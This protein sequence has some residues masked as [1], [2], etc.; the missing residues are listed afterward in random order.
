MTETYIEYRVRPVTR[1][2]VTKYTESR[3]EGRKAC[4]VGSE[5]IGVF[6]NLPKANTITQAMARTTIHSGQ[7][8]EDKEELTVWQCLF[9]HAYADDPDCLKLQVYPPQQ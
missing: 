6:D 4:A 3:K 2:L 8:C 9:D 7:I 1:Y 5:T